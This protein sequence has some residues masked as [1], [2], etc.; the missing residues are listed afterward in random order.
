MIISELNKQV[1]RKKRKKSFT[2]PSFSNP[3]PT[4][5]TFFKT[6]CGDEMILNEVFVMCTFPNRSKSHKEV[7]IQI[8]PYSIMKN[9][10]CV[11]DHL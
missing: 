10:P 5:V 3:M 6:M 11:I 1:K 2:K 7:F 8:L 4:L 9:E